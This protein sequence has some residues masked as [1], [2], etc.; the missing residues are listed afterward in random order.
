[1]ELYIGNQSAF[2]TPD[3]EEPFAFALANGFDAFEWFDDKK[4]HPDGIGTGWTPADT[5]DARRAELRT[6]AAKANFRFSVHAPWQANPLKPGGIEAIHDSM[7]FARDIGARLV[8]FHLYADE[9]PQ[10]FYDA[11]LPAFRRAAELGL[12][13]SLENTPETAPE[14]FNAVFELIAASPYHGIVGLCLD[15]GHANCCAATRND[16][17]RF[18]DL[19]S[20]A[21]HIIHCHV[22]ENWGDRDSHLTLFTGPAKKHP[23][24]VQAFLDRL[25]QR[26]YNGV[27]VLEQFPEPRTLLLQAENRLRELSNCPR[28]I[29]TVAPPP[30]QTTV[31]RQH[32]RS[33]SPCP[34]VEAAPEASAGLPFIGTPED[35][36]AEYDPVAV[37]NTFGAALVEANREHVSWRRRLNWVLDQLLAENFEPSEENLACIAVYLRF[38]G[39][40][41]LPCREDGG[42]YRPCHHARAAEDIENALLTLQDDENAWLLRRIFPWLP[43]HGEEFQRHEPLTRIRDI[44][45]RN[46]IPHDLKQRIKHDL[47][48]KLHRSAGPEDLQTS[49]AI[50]EIITRPGAE[51]APDFVTQFK[52][53]HAELQEFFNAPGLRTRLTKLTD[54]YSPL[55]TTASAF[56]RAAKQENPEEKSETAVILREEIARILADRNDARLQDSALR[57]NLRITDIELE[58]AAFAALATSAS[59]VEMECEISFRWFRTTRCALNHLKLSGT[60]AEECRAILAELQAWE[61]DFDVRDRFRALRLKATIERA[62]RICENYAHKVSDIFTPIV[63]ELGTAFHIDQQQLDV[64]VEADI[65]ANVVFQLSRLL[66]CALLRIRDAQHLPPWDV[67]VPGEATGT[68]VHATTLEEA[69]QNPAAAP[70]GLGVIAALEEAAGDEEIPPGVCAV[71]VAHPLPH[72]S[73][74]AVRARQAR[75]CFAAADAAEA[76]TSLRAL[77]KNSVFLR[78]TADMVDINKAEPHTAPSENAQTLPATTGSVAAARADL[79]EGP[80]LLAIADA[81]PETCG[82][83][84]VG[85]H[86]LIGLA[87]A[88]GGLF[89]APRALAIPFSVLHSALQS[90]PA[91]GEYDQLREELNKL[92]GEEFEKALRRLRQIICTLPIPDAITLQIQSEFGTDTRIAVRSSS[93]A[94]DL[95]GLAGAGLYDSIVGVRAAEAAGAVGAVWASLWTKRATLSRKQYGIPHATAQMAVL[96]QEM[97]EPEFSF[98]LHTADPVSMERGRVGVE[99][100]TGLGETLVSADQPGQ[101]WRLSARVEEPPQLLSCA[102]FSYQRQPS[103]EEGVADLRLDYS[104]VRLS[105]EPGTVQLLTERLAK[106]GRFIEEC[107]GC[108]QDVEGVVNGE[109]IFVVQTRPQAGL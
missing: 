40:G 61:E 103:D 106:A 81:K 71:L 98:V 88:S 31:A 104:T 62:R 102:N 3:P 69:A 8:N 34:I 12:L 94:E 47:Q 18:I 32:P 36:E 78:C 97:V 24:G 89:S 30:L 73:H 58:D 4:L 10:R 82:A 107:Q 96:V 16:F 43:A 59:K 1:M 52:I 23:G 35:H 38:I 33:P 77:D 109:A 22:H 55:A 17:I 39:T 15:I 57:Q 72:L 90:S 108:P 51:Y 70:G 74:L 27:L 85:A 60:E 80:Q 67:I 49:D 91:W 46:D 83:K 66:S 48:N 21:V 54:L 41:E 20:P 50:L 76:F 11:C 14:D 7:E 25:R 45:H 75:V 13:I 29:T 26:D 99:I 87:L 105:Q 9:A 64:F 19:L 42:H 53:F 95:A 44:A 92:N 63:Y 68:L 101:P 65:R 2:F 86:Q 93:N 79:S 56:L 100:A 28:H 5:S 6:F 84:A 37:G